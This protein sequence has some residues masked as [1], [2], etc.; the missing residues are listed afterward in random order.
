[1]DLDGAPQATTEIEFETSEP[2]D[3]VA[4]RR[5]FHG[6]EVEAR[7]TARQSSPGELGVTDV[8]TVIASSSVLSSAIKVLPEFL[9][10][11]RSGVR[12]ETSVRG[13]KVSVDATNVED[14]LAIIDRLLDGDA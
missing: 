6:L 13:R 5:W 10:S 7:F 14:V 3:L 11:R 4:L 9:R 8:L 2:D 12:I 1:M